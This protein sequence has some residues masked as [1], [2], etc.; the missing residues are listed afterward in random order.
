MGSKIRVC[1]QCRILNG[2]IFLICEN[3]APQQR[4]HILCRR[5]GYLIARGCCDSSHFSG[6]SPKCVG[7]NALNLSHTRSLDLTLSSGRPTLY[8]G[9]KQ[10]N[11]SSKWQ[12]GLGFRLLPRPHLPLHRAEP[13]S[14]ALVPPAS[15]A[16]LPRPP[17]PIHR[18]FSVALGGPVEVSLH[19][20]NLTP[21]PLLCTPATPA[22]PSRARRPSSGTKRRTSTWAPSTLR[23]RRRSHM[24]CAG[25]PRPARQPSTRLPFSRLP[26][27]CQGTAT[28]TTALATVT[29]R[30]PSQA[31]AGGVRRQSARELADAGGGGGGR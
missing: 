16:A 3:P 31:V 9:V 14:V 18:C 6:H 25:I 23:R 1:R 8:K 24:T 10:K 21:S 13:A 2:A 29:P 22:L 26:R 7:R 11:G 5:A 15:R 20:L 4:T 27:A 30:R 17:D 12:V 28:K 19:E